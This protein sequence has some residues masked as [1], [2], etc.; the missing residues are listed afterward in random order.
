MRY[1]QASGI[2][3]QTRP[4]ARSTAFADLADSAEDCRPATSTLAL[5]L[6]KMCHSQVHGTQLVCWIAGKFAKH[7]SQVFSGMRCTACSVVQLCAF[8]S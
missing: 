6:D 5:G 4:S 8:R 7:P 2:V 1:A 3:P